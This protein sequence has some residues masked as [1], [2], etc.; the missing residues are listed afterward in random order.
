MNDRSVHI[1]GPVSKSVI[2]TGDHNTVSIQISKT[3]IP[4][5]ESVDIA[6]VLAAFEKILAGLQV[7]DKD[8]QKIDNALQEAG[9]EAAEEQP[10]REEVGSALDRAL[11]VAQKAQGFAKVIDDLKPHVQSMAGWL[12]ENWHK[13]LTVVGLAG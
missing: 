5:A 3:G 12:G 11:K 1:S 9:T 10:D 6:A 13:I 2:T 4:P 8:R 7:P